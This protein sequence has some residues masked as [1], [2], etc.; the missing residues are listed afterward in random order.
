[1]GNTELMITILYGVA[2]VGIL[3]ALIVIVSAIVQRGLDRR[4]EALSAQEE[5]LPEV[6]PE[7]PPMIES[8]QEEE[9]RD[10]EPEG[11]AMGPDADAS[12]RDIR[13][14]RKLEA[15]AEEEAISVQESAPPK[16]ED[17]PPAKVEIEGL[18][19]E[20]T[21]SAKVGGYVVRYCAASHIGARK[22]QQDAMHHSPVD[23][24]TVEK[25][26]FLAVVCDGMGG[27]R[28][29]GEAASLAAKTFVSAFI[30]SKAAPQA[31]LREALDIA[32]EVVWELCK[33]DDLSGAGTTLVAALVT[34]EGMHYISVGDS[35]VYLLRGG[36]LSQLNVDHNYLSELLQKVRRGEITRDQA[37]SD[38]ERAHLTS[39]L[40][41]KRLTQVDRSSGPIQME[42]G[43]RILLAS[44]G[45]FK[46]LTPAG[47][48]ERMKAEGDDI[49]ARLIGEVLSFNYRNQDNIS[50]A[51]VALNQEEQ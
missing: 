37:L 46:V 42:A 50:V 19:A 33:T 23:E 30:A 44:D 22:E 10:D 15:P 1:M 11:I 27:M 48:A 40:G 47:I 49:P 9:P 38:P 3:I 28:M 26:G 17:M 31:A 29:G 24:E 16:A 5:A 39:Y 25:A 8:A 43:D 6:L 4:S 51:V 21:V 18:E 2:G 34:K 7:A 13:T 35:H 20:E 41:L 36:V 45:L 32:N 14:Q 12:A